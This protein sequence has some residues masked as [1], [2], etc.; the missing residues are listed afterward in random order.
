[1]RVRVREVA[2][3]PRVSLASSNIDFIMVP[4]HL[5][6][7]CT[8]IFS[9]TTM[10]GS[11]ASDGMLRNLAASSITGALVMLVRANDQEPGSARYTAVP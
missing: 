4:R 7:E 6:L 11:N 5:M 2:G 9:A 10:S 1:M 3:K 8:I